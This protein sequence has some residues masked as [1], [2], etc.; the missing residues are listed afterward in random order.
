MGDNVNNTR[1]K[2]KMVST[3][4]NDTISSK[5]KKSSVK[6][7]KTVLSISPTDEKK[8]HEEYQKIRNTILHKHYNTKKKLISPYRQRLLPRNYYT[9]PS[10]TRFKEKKRVKTDNEKLA[11]ATSFT[12]PCAYWDSQYLYPSY[13]QPTKISRS[14]GDSPV[15]SDTELRIYLQQQIQINSLTKFDLPQRTSA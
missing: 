10:V 2:Q 11:P 14:V 12:E 7:K 9:R 15:F 5:N 6:K 3:L 1:K 4:N 13:L 8:L